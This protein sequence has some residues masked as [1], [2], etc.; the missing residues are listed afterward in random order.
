MRSDEVIAQDNQMIRIVERKRTQQDSFNDRKD[1]GRRADS[2][3]EHQIAKSV[4]PGDR[5]S[6]RRV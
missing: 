5:R 4:S 6:C 2:E 3:R 1:G